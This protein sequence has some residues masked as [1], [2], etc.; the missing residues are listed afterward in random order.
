[1]YGTLA[2]F[3]IKPE[4]VDAMN[5]LM[6]DQ[7]QL[8]VPGFIASHLLRPDAGGDAFY[9]AVFFEDQASYEKNADDPAQHERYL[10]YRPLMEAEPEWTD[11]VWDSYTP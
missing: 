9:L 7:G 8:A 5:A 10:K 11:G 3:T 4:N 6:Q 1:M 2:K